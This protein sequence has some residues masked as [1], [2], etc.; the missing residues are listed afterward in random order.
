MNCENIIFFLTRTRNA[1]YDQL[2]AGLMGPHDMQEDFR[3]PARLPYALR[4]G[5]IAA[6]LAALFSM[7]AYFAGQQYNRSLQW[8]AMVIPIAL[9][10]VCLNNYKRDNARSLSMGQG[11]GLG[12]LF[13]LVYALITSAYTL[14]YMGV[15]NPDYLAGMKEMTIQQLEDRGMSDEEID[16]AMRFSAMFMKPGSIVLMGLLM[17]FIL[18]AI[19]SAITAAIVKTPSGD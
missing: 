13:F 15:I 6:L 12:M 16:T 18:G 11:F 14:L 4:Y 17:N 5:L 19:I 7:V 3:A 8:V 1:I 2:K 9:V 10:F